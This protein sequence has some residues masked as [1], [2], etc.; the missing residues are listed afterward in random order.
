MSVTRLIL[1]MHF[2]LMCV[3]LMIVCCSMTPAQTVTVVDEVDETAASSHGYMET[4]NLIYGDGRGQLRRIGKLLCDGPL[5]VLKNK[6]QWEII[7]VREGSNSCKTVAFQLPENFGVGSVIAPVKALNEDGNEI[8][9]AE[10]RRSRNML[11]IFPRDGEFSY[12]FDPTPQGAISTTGW[13]FDKLH[14]V[15][16]GMTWGDPRLTIPAAPGTKAADAGVETLVGFQVPD[17]AEPDTIFW[18]NGGG[19]WYD[20]IVL[21]LCEMDA[22]FDADT[23]QLTV[24]VTGHF[25]KR[26]DYVITLNGMNEARKTISL[27][28]GQS[29]KVVFS[30]DETT[31]PGTRNIEIT[32]NVK[33][34][35]N[36]LTLTKHCRI[37]IP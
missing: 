9:T 33:D 20:F 4:P 27:D 16:P 10:C 15:V 2:A 22:T 6:G 5:I 34:E 13:S 25:P 28:P 14:Y 35:H 1:K 32:A 37:A 3:G 23:R 36:D 8:G 30:L 11:H 7:P 19:H 18:L 17:D 29:K 21:P 12:L 26:A 31:E 24:D